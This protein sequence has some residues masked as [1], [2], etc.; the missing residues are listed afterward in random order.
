MKY[1]YLY[2]KINFIKEMRKV[3]NCLKRLGTVKSS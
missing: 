2:P 1:F 3:R